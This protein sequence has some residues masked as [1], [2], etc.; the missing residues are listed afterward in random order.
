[1]V[2]GD[3]SGIHRQVAELA[4]RAVQADVS[5]RESAFA[6]AAR[7]L[8]ADD[9][10]DHPGL[11]LA[12]RELADIPEPAGLRQGLHHLVSVH[13]AMS[14]Y[15]LRY[16]SLPQPVWAACDESAQRIIERMRVVEPYAAAPPPPGQVPIVLWQS[17]CLLDHAQMQGRDADVELVDTIVHQVVARPGLDGSLSPLDPEESPD[18][19]VYR[20]LAGLHAMADLALARRSRN[21]AARVRQVAQYHLENTQP[22]HTTS[23]PWALFAFAWS[24]DTRSFAQQQMHDVQAYAPG[25]VA[26]LLLADAARCLAQFA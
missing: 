5:P 26:G 8:L 15:S 7:L 10:A 25:A 24:A 22:D 16:E 3:F 12:F 17:L 2:T 23:E 4:R 6:A 14:A 18:V 13:V 21:W 19:W 1:M 20:E 11:L 9:P